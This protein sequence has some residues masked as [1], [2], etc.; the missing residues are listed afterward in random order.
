MQIQ[1]NRA[2]GAAPAR[3]SPASHW[4]QLAVQPLPA[5]MMAAAAAAAA[6]RLA[7]QHQLPQWLCLQWLPLQSSADFAAVSESD[8]ALAAASPRR[9]LRCTADEDLDSSAPAAICCS[10]GCC[11]CWA[12]GCGG[13]GG[14][15][16]SSAAS[17]ASASSKKLGRRLTFGFSGSS[18]TSGAALRRR[19]CGWPEQHNIQKQT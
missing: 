18:E 3:Q 9:L 6:V 1:H 11:C 12:S 7:G 5:A 19:I 16:A 14:S 2:T 13:G 4:P 17:S 8:A 10:C 15:I